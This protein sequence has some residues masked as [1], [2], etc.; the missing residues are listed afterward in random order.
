MDP[1]RGWGSQ[2]IKCFFCHRWEGATLFLFVKGIS[3]VECLRWYSQ[4][5]RTPS[6]NSVASKLSLGNYNTATLIYQSKYVILEEHVTSKESCRQGFCSIVTHLSWLF[7]LDSAKELW[8]SWLC[9]VPKRPR[10]TLTQP[11]LWTET[12]RSP[13]KQQFVGSCFY[14]MMTLA[15]TTQIEC[16]PT[17]EVKAMW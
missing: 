1:S 12:I 15:C 13:K 14:A 9:H 4:W 5:Q 3:Q 11:S 7:F 8:V 17:H 2:Q 10:I 16:A 6:S